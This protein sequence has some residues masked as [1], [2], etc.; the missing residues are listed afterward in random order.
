MEI[1]LRSGIQ[2][3]KIEGSIRQDCDSDAC[4]LN[5]MSLN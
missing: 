1:D 2:K 4:A 3:K 5:G